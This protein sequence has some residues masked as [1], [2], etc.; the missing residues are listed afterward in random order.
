MRPSRIISIV[1]LCVVCLML[2]APGCNAPETA[3]TIAPPTPTPTPTPPP[4]TVATVA[5][6]GSPAS[7]RV[8]DRLALKATATL[9]DGT[10]QDVTGQAS[11]LSSN[12]VVATVSPSGEVTA[13]A[14]GEADIHASYQGVATSV[15]V[16]VVPAVATVARV[17]ISG[18]PGSPSVG[19]RAALKAAATFSDNS[20]QDVTAAATWESSNR[21]VAQVSPSG[22]LTALAVGE[23]DIRAAYRG[24]VSAPAHVVIA[25]QRVA[26]LAGVVSDADNG[27]AVRDA[28]VEVVD[29]VNAGR[30]AITDGN[31]F[32]NLAG[33]LLGTFGVRVTASGYLPTE[34]RVTLGSGAV[35]RLDLTAKS[36]ATPFSAAFTITAFTKVQDTCLQIT[37]VPPGELLFSGTTASLSIRVIERG[38]TRAYGGNIQPDGT[39]VGSGIGTTSGVPGG[40]WRVMHDYGGTIR[41]KIAGNTV[42]G[43]ETLNFTSGC[44]GTLL[45]VSFTGSR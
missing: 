3:P 32:Y 1:A 5:I 25:P 45:V 38:I 18:V 2:V 6:A 17:T 16:S 34:A 11:W 13:A 4:A 15:H 39:F 23:V 22:E 10:T 41:G 26:T 43:S 7:A 30:F 14:P 35:T 40:R 27:R 21:V 12:T 42:N 37:P 44:P 29:G 19:D 9:S 31:G 20:S 33:L 8:G 28:R 36:A 24:V